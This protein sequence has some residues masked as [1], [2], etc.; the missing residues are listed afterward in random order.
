MSWP[1]KTG[2]RSIQ[3]HGYPMSNISKIDPR[4]KTDHGNGIFYRITFRFS[5]VT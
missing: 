4:E 1:F 5:R 2:W 3:S